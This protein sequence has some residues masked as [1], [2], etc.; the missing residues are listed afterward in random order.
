MNS[1][2]RIVVGELWPETISIEELGKPSQIQDKT[3]KIDHEPTIRCSLL[4]IRSMV[5][6]PAAQFKSKKC[7]RKNHLNDHFVEWSIEKA[8][9]D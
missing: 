2:Q 8:N 6:T 3:I 1:E 4:A 5:L 9:S 7:V